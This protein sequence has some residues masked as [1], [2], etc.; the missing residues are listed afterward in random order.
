[1]SSEAAINGLL[2]NITIALNTGKD[3]E[4]VKISKAARKVI[5]GYLKGDYELNIDK[6]TKTN[7]KGSGLIHFSFRDNDD[8][9]HY[10]F[11]T[12]D[13][14]SPDDEHPTSYIYAEGEEPDKKV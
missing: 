1:M 11:A 4:A 14:S 7:D 13:V 5:D 12:Y 8:K 3:N 6:M 10:I 9:K 2:K